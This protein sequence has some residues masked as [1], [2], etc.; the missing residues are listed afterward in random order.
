MTGLIYEIKER[1][2]PFELYDALTDCIEK[3]ESLARFSL[4]DSIY[5]QVDRDIANYLNVLNDLIAEMKLLNGELMLNTEG[6]VRQLVRKKRIKSE[7]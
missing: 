3:A 7:E 4:T 5:E 1:V 6:F 2:S